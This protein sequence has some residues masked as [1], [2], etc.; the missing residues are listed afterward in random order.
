MNLPIEN[1]RDDL[2]P[3]DL[4]IQQRLFSECSNSLSRTDLHKSN[5]HISSENQESMSP[6]Q[7]G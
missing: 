7:N 2:R 3:N 6:R 5:A 4:H 1:T